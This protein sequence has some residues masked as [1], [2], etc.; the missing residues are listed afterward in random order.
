MISVGNSYYYCVLETLAKSCQIQHK[1]VLGSLAALLVLLGSACLTPASS[2]ETRAKRS[3]WSDLVKVIA[4]NTNAKP[5]ANGE[6][7]QTH[8]I[9]NMGKDFAQL[10]TG[11]V[12]DIAEDTI[13]TSKKKVIGS[14]E[15]V[16]NDVIEKGV[17]LTEAVVVGAKDAAQDTIKET[18][19]VVNKSGASSKT[20]WRML[21]TP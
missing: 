16:A 10:P 15:S 5:A 18:E 3:I 4:N 6:E 21:G 11:G 17:N 12:K 9:N 13:D 7:I 2:S 1:T 20:V 8:D 19:K 14:V